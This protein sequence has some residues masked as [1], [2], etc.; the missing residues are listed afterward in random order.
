MNKT[1]QISASVLLFVVSYFVGK[2]IDLSDQAL[3][4]YQSL[5]QEQSAQSA[6][7]LQFPQ[8]Q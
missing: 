6:Q 8:N 5:T 1:I 4:V 2:Q 3:V 7:L